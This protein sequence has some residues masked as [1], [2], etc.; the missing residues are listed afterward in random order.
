METSKATSDWEKVPVSGDCETH[1]AWSEEAFKVFAHATRCPQCRAI[2]IAEKDAAD[3]A[4]RHSEMLEHNRKVRIA[5]LEWAGVCERYINHTFDTFVAETDEQ[6]LALDRCRALA[7]GVIKDPKRCP[8][9]IMA[10][11]PGTGKTHLACAM[12]IAC[13]DGKREAIKINVADMVREFKDSWKK[14]SETDE[15]KLF[16]YYGKDADLLILDEIGVQF[17]SDTE[18]MFIFEVINRRYERCL[19]TVLISNLSAEK[20]R[21]EVGERVLDRLREDG[22]KLLVFTG[23]SYRKKKPTNGAHAS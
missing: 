8:S 19:P 11:N 18:K 15:R 10:G 12:V 4:Q 21:D 22:G 5:N 20:L 16:E 9:I 3:K 14:D 13:V 2:S 23:E 7:D 6:R 17:G 1:G